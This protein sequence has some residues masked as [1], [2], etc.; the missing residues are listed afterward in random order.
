MV[1]TGQPRYPDL[2]LSFILQ[3]SGAGISIH[4]IILNPSHDIRRC[5]HTHSTFIGMGMNGHAKKLLTNVPP[6][7][8][9]SDPRASRF[10]EVN[11]QLEFQLDHR[12]SST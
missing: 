8:A 9:L 2:G 12:H 6:A 4:G 1:T 5:S 3:T 7:F 10:A 11:Y